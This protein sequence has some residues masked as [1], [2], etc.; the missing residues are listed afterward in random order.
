M[1]EFGTGLRDFWARLTWKSVISRLVPLMFIA[2]LLGTS[3][4]WADYNRPMSPDNLP[5]AAKVLLR[6]HFPNSR[7]AFAAKE[8]EYFSKTYK[9]ILS[10]GMK[11][12]FGRKGD[13]I[14]AEAK[15]RAIP[16]LLVPQ[17]ILEYVRNFYPGTQI[18]SLERDRRK[19]EIDLNN[20]LEL[21]FDRKGF[22][23]IDIDD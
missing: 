9:V 11:L 15:F 7:V 20:G 3:P 6:E 17:P 1:E 21:K 23:L 5:E 16:E 14:S 22:F 10:D 2:L 18:M 8:V 4:I 19:Y 12:E 13:L